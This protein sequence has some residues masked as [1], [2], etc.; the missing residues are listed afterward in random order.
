M[1]IVTKFNI[2]DT[3]YI[4]HNNKICETTII[5]IGI[6][7]LPPNIKNVT[8]NGNLIE[9]YYTVD[10]ESLVSIINRIPEG[11]LFTSRQELIDSL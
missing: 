9:I 5:G 3:V 6:S 10:G 4:L 7:V 11:N 1:E 2:N 8:T